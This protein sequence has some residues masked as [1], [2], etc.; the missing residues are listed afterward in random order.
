MPLLTSY[1]D[2]IL[3][4][5]KKYDFRF[6]W[7]IGSCHDAIIG[8]WI[9]WWLTQ[10]GDTRICNPARHSRSGSRRY[11]ADLLFLERFKGYDYYEV[12]GVAEVENN[13]SKF[14]DKI[15]SLISYENYIKKGSA[16][17]PNL[18]F[19]IFCYTL[20]IPNDELSDRIYETLIDLSRNS[21]LLWIA[22]EVGNSL[23]EKGDVDDSI[24]MPNYIKGYDCFYYYR[25]FSSVVLYG[26]KNGKKVQEFTFPKSQK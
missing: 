22:C 6:Y 24:F 4:S 23:R 15:K 12:K 11:I 26:I 10:K 8:E 20:D 21:K 3:Q 25:R 16:V 19:A 2:F 1:Q 7:M 5:L 17:Y 14:M 13:E 9:N 18:E